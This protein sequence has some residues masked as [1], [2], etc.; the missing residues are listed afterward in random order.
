MNR[1]VGIAAC[2]TAVLAAACTDSTAPESGLVLTLSAGPIVTLNALGDTVRLEVTAQN[3]AGDPVEPPSLTWFSSD[4][5]TA[6]VEDGLVTAVGE[7][8]AVVTARAGDATAKVTVEV[9]FALGLSGAFELVGSGRFLDHATSDLWVAGDH[10]YTGTTVASGCIPTVP[11][12]PCGNVLVTW[13]VSDPGQPTLVDT[14]KLSAAVVNDV[15]V[16]ADGSFAVATHEGDIAGMNGITLLDLSDPSRPSVLA[17]Y[18]DGLEP[19]VHNVWIERINAR[20]YVFAAVDG[21]APNRGIHVLDVTNRQAPVEVA[22]YC[23]G[24]SFAHDVYVR[25]G[26][27]F[28]SHWDAGLI[29]LDVGNGMRG[30]RPDDPIEVSRIVTRGGA[31]HNAWYWPERD[32]VFV[33]QEEFQSQPVDSLGVVHVVDVRD[34]T[35]PSE[36]ATIFTAGTPPHNFWLDKSRGVLFVAWYTAGLRAIDVN[37]TL[38]G[39][40]EEQE[41]VLA[42]ETPSGPRGSAS[43]WAPQ[44]H[45]GL[46]FASDIRHGLWVYRFELD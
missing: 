30:G 41:R 26:L 37:G 9:D 45:D 14:L 10:A 38:E 24:S 29:I 1:P 22:R 21:A 19:G 44:L 4:S 5:R 8:P 16:S 42:F 35:N 13:D 3:E 2:L 32:Y 43:M 40:L 17:R 11:S 34:L 18:T 28:V 25:D 15:K 39:R 46:V 23:R 36:V 12:T 6:T 31:V 20:D 27:A 7:G 33:G